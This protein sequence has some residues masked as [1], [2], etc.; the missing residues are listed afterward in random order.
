MVP[1]RSPA[2]A[3]AATE[4]RAYVTPDDLKAVTKPVLA[5]RLVLTA[6]AEL[7]QREPGDIVQD[8]LDN[9]PAPAINAV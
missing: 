4:G 1:P 2:Q 8:A 6:D 3:I 5:H 7:N 9:V